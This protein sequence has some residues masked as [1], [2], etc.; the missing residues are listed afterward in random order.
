MAD[1]GRQG[2]RV[3]DTTN[4]SARLHR[5]PDEGVRSYALN[6]LSRQLIDLRQRISSPSGRVVRPSFS[7]SALRA[8]LLYVRGRRLVS[9]LGRL[10][11]VR[12]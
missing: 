8:G 9:G 7:A 12:R 4:R 5:L 1:G 11:D 10:G 3:G 2:E 6:F